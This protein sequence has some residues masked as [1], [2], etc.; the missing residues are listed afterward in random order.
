MGESVPL[1]LCAS[2]GVLPVPGVLLAMR[3]PLGGEEQEGLRAKLGAPA[4]QHGAAGAYRCGEAQAVRGWGAGLGR[5]PAG[6]HTS[7]TWAASLSSSSG[8][9]WGTGSW[10]QPQNP[11]LA[12]LVLVH[13]QG[14]HT[15][16]PTPR[17]GW[18]PIVP[19]LIERGQGPT[20]Q[21]AGTGLLGPQP[22]R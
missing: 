2:S 10:T 4:E 17:P 5:G 12:G 15:I 3:V 8:R 6:S 11:H 7:C 9:T 13:T 1:S 16:T 18:D 21:P 19:F 22:R 14:G 20:T